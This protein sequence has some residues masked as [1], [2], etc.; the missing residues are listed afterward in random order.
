VTESGVGPNQPPQEPQWHWVDAKSE[1]E[2]EQ[3]GGEDL[4]ARNF[5]LKMPQTPRRPLRAVLYTIGSV[6]NCV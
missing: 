5:F 6:K 2:E 1:G 3:G 4:Q